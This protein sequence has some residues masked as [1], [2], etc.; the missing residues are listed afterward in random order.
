MATMR[1]VVDIKAP[2]GERV[3]RGSSAEGFTR[4]WI[5]EVVGDSSLGGSG[6]HFGSAPSPS[7]WA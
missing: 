1:H 3:R 4:W 2:R 5:K 7:E 6:M